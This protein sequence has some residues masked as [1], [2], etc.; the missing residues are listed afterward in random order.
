MFKPH[1]IFRGEC[2]QNS[3]NLVNLSLRIIDV[4]Q[5][6]RDVKPL[7]DIHVHVIIHGTCTYFPFSD[8]SFEES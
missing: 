7:E 2:C 4:K 8:A 1:Q 6:Y 5:L 3:H